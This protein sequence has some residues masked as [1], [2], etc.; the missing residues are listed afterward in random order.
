MRPY[1]MRTIYA[2]D[3]SEIIDQFLIYAYCKPQTAWPSSLVVR[4][5]D[6]GSGTLGS[7][8]EWAHILQCF[9]LS[10]FSVFMLNYFILVIWN[11][12]NDKTFHSFTFYIELC[13]KYMGE[14]V[15][16]ALLKEN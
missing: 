3:N 2:L 16:L 6:Y 9:F 10:L 5:S 15:N 12:K 13:K 4:V 8:P 11:Y 1:P 14:G 7:I